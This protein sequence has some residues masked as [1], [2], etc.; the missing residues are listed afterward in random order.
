MTVKH[1]E[2]DVK[3]YYII[4]TLFSYTGSSD[5]WS[6][7]LDSVAPYPPRYYLIE[8]LD[9]TSYGEKISPQLPGDKSGSGG[10]NK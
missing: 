1:H 9:S 10:L 7:P 8:S 2:G 6:S 4:D 5:D 3:C